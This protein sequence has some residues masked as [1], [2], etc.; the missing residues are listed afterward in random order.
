M[1]TWQEREKAM[2]EYTG[3]AEIYDRLMDGVDYGEWAEYVSALID[4]HGG[5]V[6]RTALDLACGTG[7]TTLALAR[8]GFKVTGLD[9]SGR[10]LA[11]A[12][13][14]VKQ[15]G[16][17]VDFLQA[18]MRDFKLNEAVGL[19]TAFQDGLN[20]M[21]TKED[22]R[23]AIC[24]VAGALFPGGL[25]VFDINRVE[26]LP[27]SG[28]EVACVE[29]EDFTLIFNTSFVAE[30]IWK[31]QVTGFISTAEGL[32][33][34]FSE[35]HRERSISASEVS[36]ALECAGLT[37]LGEYAAFSQEPPGR[38]TRRVFYVAVKET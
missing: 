27:K 21:L 34:R 1:L 19:V 6:R 18:D 29:S 3:L 16:L 12:A 25:F 11:V 35:E 30:N 33:R 38:D 5:L 14:K 26:K 17:Q 37:L 32:F 31:I 22:F 4:R 7:S 23:M 9:L 28:S 15:E 13:E 24:S 20:Y 10:M 2:S 36:A 8:H